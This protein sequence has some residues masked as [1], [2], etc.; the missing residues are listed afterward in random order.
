MADFPLD[1]LMADLEDATAGFAEQLGDL[2][3]FE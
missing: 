1:K 3:S 2:K